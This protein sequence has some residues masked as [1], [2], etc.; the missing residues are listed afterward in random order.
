M[1]KGKSI[2]RFLPRLATMVKPGCSNAKYCKESFKLRGSLYREGCYVVLE[3]LGVQVETV[4]HAKADG[5]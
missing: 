2:P 3:S 1:S 5:D 4:Q